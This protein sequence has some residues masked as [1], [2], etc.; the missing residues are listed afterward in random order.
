MI[1]VFY[2][3]GGT[4]WKYGIALSIVYVQRLENS[5]TFRE[6]FLLDVLLTYCQS[7]QGFA[8]TFGAILLS[9]FGSKIRRWHVRILMDNRVTRTMGL[10]RGVLHRQS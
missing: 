2:T 3:N 7:R 8:I 6:H 4:D 9:V 5:K 1:A 10:P